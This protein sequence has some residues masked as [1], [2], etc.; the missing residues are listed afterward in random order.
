M[1]IANCEFIPKDRF[2]GTAYFDIAK[3]L[4][5]AWARLTDLVERVEGIRYF[6]NGCYELTVGS[7][8]CEDVRWNH[9]K[10]S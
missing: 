3:N 9:R 4:T 1:I 7:D 6:L 10:C 8:F 5:G 2:S